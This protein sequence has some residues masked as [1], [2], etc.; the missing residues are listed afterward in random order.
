MFSQVCVCSQWEGYPSQ[1]SHPFSFLVGPK[2]LVPGPF[3][4]VH[5][6]QA[7]SQG[8]E[9]TPVRK[10]RGTLPPDP[11]RLR[12]AW[13]VRILRSRRRTFLSELLSFEA[14]VNVNIQSYILFVVETLGGWKFRFFN[15][16]ILIKFQNI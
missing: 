11:D 8:E 9:G 2:P 1:T 13:A 15:K 14:A 16:K 7:C 5:P 6:S 3:G 12:H 4:G 10:N